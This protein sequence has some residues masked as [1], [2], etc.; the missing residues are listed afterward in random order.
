MSEQ[1][2]IYQAIAYLIDKQPRSSSFKLDMLAKE[3]HVLRDGDIIIM[4]TYEWNDEEYEISTINMADRWVDL[5]LSALMAINGSTDYELMWRHLHYFGITPD[6]IYELY[7]NSEFEY[8]PHY[9][10]NEEIGD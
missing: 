10:T 5:T 6:K 7:S 3:Y 1:K 2:K 4:V 8:Y 9:D